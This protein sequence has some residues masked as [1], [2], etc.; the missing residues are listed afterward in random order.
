MSIADVNFRRLLESIILEGYNSGE[1]R[2]VYEDGTQAKTFYLTNVCLNYPLN[3]G[4]FPITQL[5]PIAW[6]SAIKEMMVIY[7]KQEHTAQAF[8]ESGVNW[9]KH[10]A[11]D[12][13]GNLGQRY[14]A[15]V[16]KYN[17]IDRLLKGLEE[18]PYNRRNIINLWQYEDLDSTDGLYPC[19]FQVMFDVRPTKDSFLL[20]C[21][22]VQRSSDVLTAL[23]INE[24]Q[25]VALQMMIAKHFGWE[26]GQFSHYIQ[27]AHIYTNQEKALEALLDRKIENNDIQPKL[28]LNCEPKTNFYDIKIEDFELI[29]YEPIKPQIEI[30]LAF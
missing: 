16:R 6:K 2:P 9:W 11:I 10:W 15:T 4:V 22:L 3:A 21:T 26:V 14:G 19:A 27:N 8:E 28:L 20:D 25:Y 29:D 5:R 24:I 7:Q 1:L 23:H 13:K 30:P 12:D 17:I 18:N